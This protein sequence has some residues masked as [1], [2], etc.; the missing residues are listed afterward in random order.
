M[1]HD[2][3]IT[4]DGAY[5]ANNND[6]AGLHQHVASHYLDIRPDVFSAVLDSMIESG[7]YQLPE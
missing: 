4:T 6:L 7:K 2:F 3:F 1:R 5:V